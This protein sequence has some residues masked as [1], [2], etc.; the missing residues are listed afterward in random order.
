MRKLKIKYDPTIRKHVAS[1]Y[2]DNKLLRADIAVGDDAGTLLADVATMLA[3]QAPEQRGGRVEPITQKPSDGDAA[4]RAKMDKQ[5]LVMAEHT[6]ITEEENNTFRAYLRGGRDALSGIQRRALSEGTD[7]AGGYLVPQDFADRIIVSLKQYDQLFDVATV[8]RTE[9]GN[10]FQVPMDDDTGQ[11]AAIVLENVTSNLAVDVV[12]DR[13][14]FPKCPTW[15]SGLV[16]VDTE[17]AE[18]SAFNLDEFLA[19]AFARRFA[20]GIGAYFVTQLLSQATLGKTAAS[21]TAVVPDELLDLMASVDAAYAQRGA[22][23]MN[24]PTFTSIVK[25]KA[26]TG[27]SYLAD[28]DVDPEG[29][30]LLFTRQA[31]LSPSMP[32]MTTGL[33]SVAFGDLTRFIRREVR[34]SLS[35]RVYTERYAELGEIAYESFYR[36]DG[37]L[38][39]AANSP[40]P[41]KYLQQA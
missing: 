13:V 6:K 27:G 12:F 40:I 15:R 35:L 39:K 41:V 38:A 14:A 31:Y 34:N 9:N 18:D 2:E 23:L 20:R 28:V 24:F 26:S 36:C 32:N 37:M 22:F 25:V 30:P 17:L 16:R 19:A 4:R 10:A 8:I 21:P 1:L 33:K 29:H 11:A 7:A 5:K 3:E